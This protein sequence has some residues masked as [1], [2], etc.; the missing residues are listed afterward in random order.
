MPELKKIPTFSWLVRKTE[1]LMRKE[2]QSYLGLRQ[3]GTDRLLRGCTVKMTCND[4]G[5]PFVYRLFAPKELTKPYATI[6][7]HKEGKEFYT[8]YQVNFTTTQYRK[9]MHKWLPVSM[10]V[11]V[12]CGLD[13]VAHYFNADG[14]LAYFGQWH[15]GRERR[16]GRPD[17]DA[18]I[19]RDRDGK[20]LGE[21]AYHG[22]HS[23]ERMQVM[24]HLNTSNPVDLWHDFIPGS[25]Q[26]KLDWYKS[27]T[28]PEFDNHDMV[29]S[30]G[31]P[32]TIKVSK[33]DEPVWNEIRVKTL[34]AKVHS[35]AIRLTKT[36]PHIKI[37]M[38]PGGPWTEG[39]DAFIKG[40]MT[41]FSGGGGGQ[42]TPVIVGRDSQGEPLMWMMPELVLYWVAP[43][44]ET[45]H[46]VHCEARFIRVVIPPA[47]SR[48]LLRTDNLSSLSATYRWGKKNTRMLEMNVL[49]RK[50]AIERAHHQLVCYSIGN[51]SDGSLW[52][53]GRHRG[54]PFVHGKH[55]IDAKI[56]NWDESQS[57]VVVYDQSDNTNYWGHYE[58]RAAK[59]EGIFNHIE[60]REL[61][62][63]LPLC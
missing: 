5:H 25:V 9:R 54:S 59:T 29:A 1:A 43:K 24:S 49:H 44:H 32:A 7:G 35:E 17:C 34:A 8:V 47:G 51:P 46:Q 20:F 45:S 2:P 22:E 33:V 18:M 58:A 57:V 11:G 40:T 52:N 14:T 36:Y 56:H 16:N 31:V 50:Q 4:A 19:I 41:R 30:G 38:F 55:E 42:R 61:V 21:V 23:A 48:Q 28:P 6:M 15:G 10:P 53:Y 37:A 26:S 12:R 27:M 60:E 39:G 13:T 63:S 62:D 3:A